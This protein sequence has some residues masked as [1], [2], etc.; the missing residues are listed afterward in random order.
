MHALVAMQHLQNYYLLTSIFTENYL[1]LCRRQEM[2]IDSFE[3]TWWMMFPFHTLTS[4]RNNNK[5]NNLLSIGQYRMSPISSTPVLS[6][7]LGPII[8]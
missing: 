1:F 4:I 2:E 5:L 7:L 6:T 3:K 8:R